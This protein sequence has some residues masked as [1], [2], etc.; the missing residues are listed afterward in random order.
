MNTLDEL[1]TAVLQDEAQDA[2]RS[3]P[4]V[5]RVLGDAP[6]SARRSRP[7]WAAPAAAAAVVG[8]V[9]AAAIVASL[10]PDHGSAD[11]ATTPATTT[12]APSLRTIPPGHAGRLPGWIDLSW[13]SVHIEMDDSASRGGFWWRSW[14]VG[15]SASVLS[16]MESG[17]FACAGPP[18]ERPRYEVLV[19]E[20]DAPTNTV[21]ARINWG[22]PLRPSRITGPFD[23]ALCGGPCYQN[24]GGQTSKVSSTTAQVRYDC[25]GVCGRPTPRT[26][27]VID[28]PEQDAHVTILSPPGERLNWLTDYI[29]VDR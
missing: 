29:Y 5:T 4:F 28:F 1:V 26:L 18:G 27:T 23:R 12:S 15:C 9:A 7:R 17:D 8:L 10:W 6:R 22:G 20:G 2:P 14:S 21:N 13:A 19:A 3:E 24:V 25:P 16:T 11:G